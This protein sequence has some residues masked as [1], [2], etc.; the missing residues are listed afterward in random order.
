METQTKTSAKDFFINLGAIV[1]L[2][3]SVVSL[4]NLLFTIIN[5]SYPQINNGYNLFGSSSISWPVAT[6]IIFF[7]IFLLLMWLLEKDY[8]VYPEKQSMGIHRWLTYITLFI[9]GLTL[10][11]DLITV[12]YYFLDGQELTTGFVLKVIAILVVAGAIFSYYLSDVLGK[13]TAKLRV[14]YRIVACAFIIGA[15][16]WGFAVLGS[17]Q[18]QRMYKYDAQ[19]VTEL[20]NISYGVESFY[21][22]KGIVPQSLTE[23][24]SSTY[25]YGSTLDPQSQKPYEYEKTGNLT[26]NLCALFNKASPEVTKPDIYARPV[27]YKSWTHEAGRHCF[28]QTINPNLYSKPVPKF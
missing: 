16:I 2:Y 11:I 1:A 7:P 23:I 5:T 13:L 21:G 28:E 4:L 14:I 19:K 6:L 25:F 27:G 15:I 17:P 24:E 3:T 10:A 12:L 8:R 9:A 26:Y 22:D 18:T 20:Q